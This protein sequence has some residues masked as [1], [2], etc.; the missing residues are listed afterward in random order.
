MMG[1][2]VA[3]RKGAGLPSR[4]P[5]FM[6]RPPRELALRRSPARGRIPQTVEEFLPAVPKVIPRPLV[7]TF[8]WTYVGRLISEVIGYYDWLESLVPPLYYGSGGTGNTAGWTVTCNM[9]PPQIGFSHFAN[10]GCNNAMINGGS[11]VLPGPA[12][13]RRKFTAFNDQLAI[14]YC[15][16]HPFGPNWGYARISATRPWPVGL[17]S[18]ENPFKRQF[19]PVWKERA[20]TGWVPFWFP[21]LI[22]PRVPVAPP[23][24]I[25]FRYI[26]LVEPHGWPEG[27]ERGNNAPQPAV[28]AGPEPFYWAPWWMDF[29]YS[30]WP[31]SVSAPKPSPAPKPATGSPPRPPPV[32]TNPPT[33]NWLR[34]LPDFGPAENGRA[35]R[36]G[37]IV[38]GK[39]YR[40]ER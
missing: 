37:D 20:E 28:A 30:W 29:D 39:G 21:E 13:V 6:R 22:P 15:V 19:T 14:N 31:S 5:A 35:A 3:Y 36:R 34:S 17:P 38:A 8:R 32:R 9:G 18:P 12:Y 16:P 10:N 2:P 25:P 27:S 23:A 1:Y 4:P 24:S 7:N 26:P 11:V 33:M 40:D